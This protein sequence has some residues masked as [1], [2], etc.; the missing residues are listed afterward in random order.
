GS[1]SILEN[2][3]R[4]GL[5]ARI[6]TDATAG[7]AVA[8]IFAEVI[9]APV[10]LVAQMHSAYG[11]CFD[12]QPASF[13]FLGMHLSPT[14]VFLFFAFRHVESRLPWARIAA[15]E[16]VSIGNS[17]APQKAAMRD[18]RRREFCAQ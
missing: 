14:A 7:A 2:R 12:A 8:L 9:T 10:E 18:F 5:R 4:A 16:C 1:N 17:R 3:D 13:A 11:A 6:K 15:T